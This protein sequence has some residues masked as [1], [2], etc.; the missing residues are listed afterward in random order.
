[1]NELSKTVE[2]FSGGILPSYRH[3]PLIEVVCGIRFQPSPNFTLPYFGL[4]WNKFREKYPRIQHA[5][6]LMVGVNQFLVD[7]VTG[8]PLPR[9]W[10][11]NSQDDQLIQFQ[12]DHIYFN[13]R[14][15]QDVYP[16]Y[17]HVIH[18]FEEVF[19]TIKVFFE[20][21]TLG[22]FT[23]IECELTYLNHIIK[24]Q[25]KET[26]DE[27]KRIFKDFS[28]DKSPRFLSNPI[29][30]S[31]NLS[32]LLPGK[33]GNLMVSLHEG[34]RKEDNSPLFVLQ[35]TAKGIG[36]SKDKQGIREWFDTAHEWIVRGFA[37][38]T[39]ESIQIEEWGKENV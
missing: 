31:W 36:H 16:R 35:L 10:F 37:D 14:Q 34:V 8:A 22:N 5:A 17:R 3:P 29:N 6:P 9:V 13:W 33:K 1:M 24:R 27:L 28:W 11:I 30:V 12:L 20:E 19:D 4:L 32:F 26:A 23:P 7:T 25:D 39:T 2:R 38:L 21:S 15:R 18:N